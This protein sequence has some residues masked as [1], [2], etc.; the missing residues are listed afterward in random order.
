MA[1]PNQSLDSRRFQREQEA[2]L[3]ATSLIGLNTVKPFIQFQ[4]SMLRMLSESCEIMARN[5][6][7]GLEAFGTAV[8]Q[9]QQ[10]THQHQ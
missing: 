8:E 10:S 5:Y 3:A 7:Q 2:R 6:E 4:T 1:E 9:R